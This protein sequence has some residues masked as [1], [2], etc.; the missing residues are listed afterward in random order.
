MAS[1]SLSVAS[2]SSSSQC[3][4]FQFVVG[5]VN[6]RLAILGVVRGIDSNGL[7]LAQTWPCGLWQHASVLSHLDLEPVANGGFPLRRFFGV[8]GANLAGRRRYRRVT[9]TTRKSAKL[10]MPFKEFQREVI[11]DGGSLPCTLLVVWHLLEFAHAVLDHRD[12]QYRSHCF[13][14]RNSRSSQEESRST[15]RMRVR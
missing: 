7:D 9:S 5:H 10:T 1:Y 11:F 3:W 14:L 15:G 4:T 6:T 8:S 2:S 12:G 13:P